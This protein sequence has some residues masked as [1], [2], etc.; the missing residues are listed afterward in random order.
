LK[1][2]LT[3]KMAPPTTSKAARIFDKAPDIRECCVFLESGKRPRHYD[4]YMQNV[5]GFKV[6]AK[7][8]HDDAPDSLAMLIDMVFRKSEKPVVFKRPF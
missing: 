6:F 5:Y 2:N 8:K 4:A 1:V 7:N 3:T